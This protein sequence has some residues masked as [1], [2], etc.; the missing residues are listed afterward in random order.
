MTITTAALLDLDVDATLSEVVRLP[1]PR[2]SRELLK[3]IREALKNTAS[4]RI[5]RAKAKLEGAEYTYD[6][7]VTYTYSLDTLIGVA[8]TRTA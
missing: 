5:A 8:V 2:G 7:F 4:N 6:S 1:D 3:T